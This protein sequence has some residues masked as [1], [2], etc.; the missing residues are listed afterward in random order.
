MGK[1]KEEERKIGR[2]E[3]DRQGES[4]I[5]EEGI[6]GNWQRERESIKK[7]ETA[8]TTAGLRGLLRYNVS[9]ISLR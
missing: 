2:K 6:G 7:G 5:G 9:K 1:K 3:R 4:V 8:W